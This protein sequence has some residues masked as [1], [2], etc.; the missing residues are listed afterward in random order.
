MSIQLKNEFLSLEFEEPGEIYRGT[1]FDR[2]GQIVQITYLNRHTF[3][4]S[5]TLD[6]NLN[7]KQGRGLF[8]EFGIDQPIGYDSCKIGES[9]PKIGVGDLIKENDAHYDFFHDYELK[10]YKFSYRKEKSSVSF[11]C[12]SGITNGYSFRLEKNI[13]LHENNFT[14][15]YVLYNSGEKEIN[16]NEYIH[17]FLAINKKPINEDYKLH[18]PFPLYPDNFAASVNPNDVISFAESYLTCS[19]IPKGQFFFKNVETTNEAVGSWTLIHEGEKVGISEMTDSNV[20]RIN[21]WGSAHVISPEI[22]IVVNVSPG[23]SC[24]WNRKYSLFSID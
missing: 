9:F 15:N 18:L 8:N 17:N 10:P 4:T 24:S 6:E 12:E 3:C 5:E 14:I 22:F 21:I 20:Q 11:L 2:T 7:N 1:R 13:K 16:T 19:S 23:Q